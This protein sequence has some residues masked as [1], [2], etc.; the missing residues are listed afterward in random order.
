MII[1]QDSR[2]QTPLEFV[3]GRAVRE[4]RVQGMPF[5]DYWGSDDEGKEFPVV[6]ERK[7]IGDLFGTLTGGM[8]RFKKMLDKAEV[9]GV[10]VYLLIDGT[11]EQVYQGYEHS[12]VP[13]EQIVRTIFSLKVRRGLEPIFCKSKLEMKAHIVET[14]QAIERNWSKLAKN[15]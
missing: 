7:S 11:L 4:V 8:E 6:F 5:A 15:V 12:S 13:G 1:I 2:E 14:Y 9:V 10:Q 3:V